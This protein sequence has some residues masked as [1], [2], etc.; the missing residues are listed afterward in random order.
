MG[1]TRRTGPRSRRR[2][3]RA[4]ARPDEDV[5]RGDLRRFGLVEMTRQNVTDGPR[6]IMTRK[7]PTCGGDGIVYSEARRLSTSS[8]GCARSSRGS[9]SSLPASSSRHDCGGVDRAR[10]GEACASFEAM[11]KRPFLS[12]GQAGHA[13][14]TTS[15]CLRRE[16]RR[17][18][19]PKGARR[20]RCGAPGRAR[21]GR[22]HD[23]TAG[24]RQARR[25]DVCVS[26]AASLVA[27]G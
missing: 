27:S 19:A 22:P 15:W 23:G 14:S 6:E 9:R 5:R 12:R 17:T 1:E 11:T 3:H 13:P 8:A 24:R 26:E 4:R 2:C 25:L 18:I 7:C 16:A 20:G 21:R 10:C